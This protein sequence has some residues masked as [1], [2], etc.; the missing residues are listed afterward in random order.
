MAWMP[1][2]D[3]SRTCTV[4]SDTFRPP[5]SCSCPHTSTLAPGEVK[6]GTF[7]QMTE[8]ARALGHHD[9]LWLEEHL[10]GRVERA[11]REARQYRKQARR[12]LKAGIVKMGPDGPVDGDSDS[13]AVKW[14]ALAEQASGRA[15]K[16]ARALHG[17]VSD[18]ERRA[19]VERMERLA[20]QA[21]GGKTKRGVA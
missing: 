3:G 16:I 6:L 18:R 9:R 2:G 8:R 21:L 20:E 5:R 11:D 4:C 17:V 10:I 13:A 15:D 19:E 12:I 14:C 7:E 1:N